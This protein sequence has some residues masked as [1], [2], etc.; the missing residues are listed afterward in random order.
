MTRVLPGLH[1]I[2]KLQFGTLLLL[3]FSLLAI[4]TF[5]QQS[6][7]L[8]QLPSNQLGDRK[9]DALEG[10]VYSLVTNEGDIREVLLS[11]SRTVNLSI[12]FEPEVK[13]NVTVDLKEVTLDEALENL[14]KPLGF[15][16]K[17][18]DNFIKVFKPKVQ[19]RN[20]EV[21]FVITRRTGSRTTSAATVATGGYGGMAGLGGPGIV[22]VGT[23]GGIGG[24]G[25]V[26]GGGS[27]TSVTGTDETDI[28]RELE[29]GIGSILYGGSNASYRDYYDRT[30]IQPP[31]EM[32]MDARGFTINRQAGIVTVNDYPE[33][34]NK[35]AKYLEIVQ[36][37]IE[38]QVL[39]QARIVEVILSNEFRSG[40]NWSMV[41]NHFSASQNLTN[42][43]GIFQIGVL[44]G[45]FKAVF[46]LLS[47]QGSVNV[48]ASPMTIAMNN[49][50][51]IMRVGT[52][53]V[54]FSTTALTDSVSGRVIQST[55]TP[56]AITEGVVLSVTPQ[57]SS[58]GFIT[59][60]VNP[61]ITERTGTATSPN[62]DTVPI[63]SVRETDTVVKVREGE[64]IVIGGLI[65]ESEK[66]EKTG[67][68]GLKSI[69]LL[70]RAFQRTT[71][72]TLKSDLA[73]LLTPTIMTP[74]RIGDVAREEIIK[75]DRL[76]S[77]RYK[78]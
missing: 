48:L 67:V 68:P 33:N 38:R 72:G 64:T 50:P 16:Y 56:T 35:V 65:K 62:G 57:I 47:T 37:A 42:A 6:R 17:K 40:I 59:M 4:D 3:A 58:D 39:I 15:D 13:G 70:G 18:E 75:L 19:T 31:G 24:A 74:D 29:V 5:S 60:N 66:I 30:H 25:I 1:R 28:W 14:L 20:F 51:S 7:V 53:D 43:G 55:V 63:L 41:S 71:R 34:L 27:F 10:K 8:R 2:T 46:D 21:N 22:G 61:S 11:L 73:I 23:V 12:T 26:S 78:P 45:N 52:Q 32:A 9:H 76:K 77:A 49:T 69:P 54:F 44:S 36:A